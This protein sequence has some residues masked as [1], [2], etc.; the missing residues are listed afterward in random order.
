MCG[1]NIV[2][3]EMKSSTFYLPP[4]GISSD[5]WLDVLFNFLFRKIVYNI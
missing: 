1:I 4:C 5:I 2:G 3:N